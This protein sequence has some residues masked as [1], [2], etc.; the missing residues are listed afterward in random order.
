[1]QRLDEAANALDRAAA[2]APDSASTHEVRGM[3]LSRSG[4]GAQAVESFRRAVEI[5]PESAT[6]WINLGQ[7]LRQIGRFAEAAD[8]FRQILARR[9]GAVE[10]YT[11]MASV[12]A[13][14]DAAEMAR[15]T[16]SRQ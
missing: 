3:I 7:A 5:A 16:A 6:G 12:G 10:A 11:L 13:T 1:M 4:R 9:P 2:L 15:L 14:A 8:C